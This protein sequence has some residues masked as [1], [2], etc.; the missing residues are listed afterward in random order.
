MTPAGFNT[1]CCRLPHTSY[2]VQWGGAQ[3]W[4]VAGKVFAIAWDEPGELHVTFKVTP[5]G[6]EVLKDMPGLRPAPYLAS[7]GMTWIQ[8]TSAESM[9]D[10]AL[11]DC[12]AESHRLVAAGLTK[13][14][15]RELGLDVPLSAAAGNS[16]KAASTSSSATRT[17][18][19]G[20]GGKQ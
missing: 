1:F 10:N 9:D 20:R 7:R 2:V 19:V 6:F 13:R 8:R 4:K 11:R 12:L 3:V 18:R 17:Q 16:L 5:L 14:L 15:Q